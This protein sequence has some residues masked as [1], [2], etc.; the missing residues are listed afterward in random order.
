MFVNNV[1]I[2]PQQQQPLNKHDDRS[3]MSDIIHRECANI[4]A[5]EGYNPLRGHPELS[6]FSLSQI[7]NYVLSH[8]L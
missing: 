5:H 8:S 3:C 6:F 4:F 7:P 2:C 1:I